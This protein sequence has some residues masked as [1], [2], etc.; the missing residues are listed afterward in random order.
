MGSARLA[1]RH[2][3]PVLGI[4]PSTL[5]SDH[6]TLPVPELIAQNES[7]KARLIPPADTT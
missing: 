3:Q 5:L 4:T 2:F 7:I 1:A 6:P